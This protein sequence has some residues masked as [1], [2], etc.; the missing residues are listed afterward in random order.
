MKLLIQLF[1]LFI[2]IELYAQPK[3]TVSKSDVLIGE[4][5]TIYYEISNFE[6]GKKINFNPWKKV[7]SCATSDPNSPAKELEILLF[8]DTIFQEEQTQWIAAYTVIAWD[9]GTYILP[10]QNYWID[11]QKFQFDTVK[12]HV[13][14]PKTSTDDKILES[15]IPFQDYEVDRFYQLKLFL[16]WIIGAFLVL[17]IIIWFLIKRKKKNKTSPENR[18]TLLERTLQEIDLLENKKYIDQNKTKELYIESSLIFRH[19]LANE[20]KLNI[21]EKTS[22]QTR[23]LLISKGLPGNLISDIQEL[24]NIFD[25]VKF[26]KFNPE[27]NE[28]KE[29]L[30]QVRDQVLKINKWRNKDV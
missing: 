4:P 3:V 23:I 8:R 6:K 2:S 14:F 7:I 24:F 13:F 28:A 9:T 15:E 12:L 16:P 30:N 5:T 11:D 18:Q 1:L 21:L 29:L 19:F 26:A 17:I 20:F 25:S 10:Q 22:S 27:E